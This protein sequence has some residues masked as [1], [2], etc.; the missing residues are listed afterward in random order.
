MT[1]ENFPS[2]WFADEGNDKPTRP[3]VVS[4]ATNNLAPNL[5]RA[6]LG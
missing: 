2:I 5:I 1:I 6:L 3:V 4:R